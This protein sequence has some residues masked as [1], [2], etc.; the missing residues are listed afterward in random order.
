[1]FL[2]LLIPIFA[3]YLFVGGLISRL[4]ILWHGENGYHLGEETRTIILVAGLLL[5]PV[6]LITIILPV[7][8]VRKIQNWRS[9]KKENK[10][11]GR[12]NPFR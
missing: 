6:L 1:M 11:N 12:T 9:K 2:R 4:F 5:W 7:M 3:L 10:D 8:V